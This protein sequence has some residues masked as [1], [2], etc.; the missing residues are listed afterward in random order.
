MSEPAPIFISETHIDAS[1]MNNDGSIDLAVTGGTSPYLYS[2]SNGDTTEDITGLSSGTYTVTVTDNNLC[3]DTI[4]IFIDMSNGLPQGPGYQAPVIYPNPSDGRIYFNNIL[5][6][7]SITVFDASG[8][9]LRTEKNVARTADLNLPAGM[10][11][12]V[13]EDENGRIFTQK[14]NIAK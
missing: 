10:Y 11:L 2:W 3:Q 7:I 9:I 8:R 5:G 6:E 14:I 4:S 12:I 13:M 1:I